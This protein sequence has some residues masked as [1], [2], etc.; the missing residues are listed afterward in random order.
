[1]ILNSIFVTILF[2][3]TS[4]IHDVIIE[5]FDVDIEPVRKF[6]KEVLQFPS[7]R[8]LR[9]PVANLSPALDL[10]ICI[11]Y[12]WFALYCHFDNNGLNFHVTSHLKIKSKVFKMGFK[13]KMIINH[14]LLS[15]TIYS[16]LYLIV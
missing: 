10:Q 8:M 12:L 15:R 5:R 1:M 13:K 7:Y 11:F 6:R 16:L 9:V 14:T 4:I 3:F 2:T